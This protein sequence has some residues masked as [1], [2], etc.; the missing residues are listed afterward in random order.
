MVDGVFGYLGVESGVAQEGG[1][2][3]HFDFESFNISKA[4]NDWVLLPLRGSWKVVWLTG[5]T[6]SHR[7]KQGSLIYSLFFFRKVKK[8]NAFFDYL[9][10]K[11]GGNIIIAEVKESYLEESVTQFREENRF[12]FGVS[13]FGEI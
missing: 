4:K 11:L 10:H 7:R 2:I 6:L 9:L 13:G 8:F 5:V 3:F 1:G 12:R